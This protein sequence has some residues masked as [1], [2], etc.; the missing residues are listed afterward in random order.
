MAAHPLRCSPAAALRLARDR[1]EHVRERSR[2]VAGPRHD[3]RA[4]QVR[5]L[6]EVAAVSQEQRAETELAGLR[7]GR[8]GRTTD[9]GAADD[10]RD[11]AELEPRFSAFVALA[12]PCRRRTCDN[13]CAIT[14]TTSP[15]VAA[16]SNM[17]RLTNI[18][19]PGSAKA[20]ISFMLTGVNEYS[21][22]IV[23]ARRR[24]RHQAIAQACPDSWRSAC[25]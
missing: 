17:P 6:F 20:L 15:S 23:E 13:S 12:V 25:P 1:L 7:D 8:T 22:R 10:A 2:I 4:E 3:L 18:G 9:D 11:L 24:D 19:P 16:A 14:P 5:L 21:R